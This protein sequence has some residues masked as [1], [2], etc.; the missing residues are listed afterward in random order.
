MTGWDKRSAKDLA[1]ELENEGFEDSHRR[2][3]GNHKPSAEDLSTV[4][5]DVRPEVGVDPRFYFESE[6]ERGKSDNHRQRALCSQVKR[7]LDQT[8][9]DFGDPRLSNVMIDSVEPGKR[10]SNLTVKVSVMSDL[11]END[12]AE[13]LAA[14]N[15]ARGYLRSEVAAAITR[16]RT[17]N[18]SFKF[19]D[20]S[21]NEA[22]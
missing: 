19:S 20:P 5:A 1:I 9:A 13:I 4:V 17:P 21:D 22:M 2:P 7:A 14:L 11:Q 3:K 8:L 18:L 12:P 15:G 16:K 6:G 10:S